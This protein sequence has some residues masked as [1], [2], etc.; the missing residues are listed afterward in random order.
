MAS[1]LVFFPPFALLFLLTIIDL[2][3]LPS[4]APNVETLSAGCPPHLLGRVCM[5]DWQ[6]EVWTLEI[7]FCEVCYRIKVF[8]NKVPF[9]LFTEF[10]RFSLFAL[11]FTP[12]SHTTRAPGNSPPA[13]SLYQKVVWS[14]GCGPIKCWE[15]SRVGRT[16]QTVV[17]AWAG[18][19]MLE[20]HAPAG[21]GKEPRTPTYSPRTPFCKQTRSNTG[22]FL[23]GLSVLM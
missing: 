23:S 1:H 14:F 18:E 6:L 13:H 11:W 4:T 3:F 19:Q 5:Q 16:N 7:V 8:R 17:I 15:E 9:S 12:D 22:L 20:E 10:I 21:S 2:S